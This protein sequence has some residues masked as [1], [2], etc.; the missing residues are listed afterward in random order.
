MNEIVEITEPYAPRHVA[1]IRTMLTVAQTAEDFV[2]IEAAIRSIEEIMKAA[3]LDPEWTARMWELNEAKMR[4]R[5]ELGRRLL[6]MERGQ[7]GPKG[8]TCRPRT[9]FKNFIKSIGLKQRSAYNAQIIAHIPEEELDRLLEE[10]QGGRHGLMTYQKLI[11]AAEPFVR[12]DMPIKRYNGAKIQ[13]PEGETVESMV[14]AGMKASPYREEGARVAGMNEAI[15]MRARAVVLVQRHEGLSPKEQRLA[16]YALR[17]MNASRQAEGPYQTI[18]PTYDRIWGTAAGFRKG[19]DELEKR[20]LVDFDRAT[21]TIAEVCKM[22]EQIPIP[23]TGDKLA[24][25]LAEMKKAQLQLRSFIRKL[26]GFQC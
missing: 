25:T 20:R 17:E 14:D 3:K 6:A 1:Q 18:L 13:V 8:D 22:A 7:P 5:W 9:Q 19:L 10:S 21:A 12:P 11:D 16:D 24:E 15:F 26:E 23:A 4:A 2:Q